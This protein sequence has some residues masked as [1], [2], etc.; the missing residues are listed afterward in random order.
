MWNI[1]DTQLTQLYPYYYR[2]NNSENTL[3]N[4]DKL[5]LLSDCPNTMEFFN[6]LGPGQSVQ[7]YY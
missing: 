4:T 2:A 6:T 7:H 5:L 1:A 3:E